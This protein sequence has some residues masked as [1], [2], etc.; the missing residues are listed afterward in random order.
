MVGQQFSL[1]SAGFGLCAI[2][3]I[4]GNDPGIT[5]VGFAPIS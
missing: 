2:A 5:F 4:I 3:W 1:G